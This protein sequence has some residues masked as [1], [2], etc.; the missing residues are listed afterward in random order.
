[1]V[2]YKLQNL[3]FTVHNLPFTILVSLSPL[4][5]AI[6]GSLFSDQS[7][8]EIFSD[9][10]FVRL[11]VRVEVSLAK[12]QARLGVIPTEAGMAIATACRDFEPDVEMLADS[13]AKASVPIIELVRQLR[14]RIGFEHAPYLHWGATTQDIMDTALVLQI[15]EALNYLEGLLHQLIDKLATIADDHRSTLMPGRTHSQQA[16]P[17][18]FGLKVA[19]WL[20]PLLRH[21][22]RLHELRPRV[23]NVQFSGAAGTLASFGD[24]GL[25]I[26][27]ALAEELGLAPPLIGWHTGRDALVETAGW[28]SLVTGSLAKIGQDIILMAQSEIGEIYESA[29]VSR[30]GSSTMPQKRN[31]VISELLVAIH[32]QN[33]QLLAGMHQAMVQEHERATHGWQLEWL[34]LP[35][36]FGM[37]AASLSKALFLANNLIVRT[38]R[39]AAN[40]AASNG[41]M[42]GEAVN[43]ALADFMDRSE[44]KVLVKD[45]V[46]RVYWEDRHL[47]DIVREMVDFPIDWGK[48]QNEANYLGATDQ[49]ID[50]VLARI[51]NKE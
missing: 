21:Q 28:L 48:L 20:A 27:K 8:R 50:K 39:M 51:K 17:I 10:E 38:D 32:R 24:E 3:P 43:F 11:L 19:Y 30:G 34:N 7:L 18:T 1:M 46:Q 37:T 31:P 33:S 23:L 40:V 49:M 2:K 29:D 13:T 47:V 26:Q 14:N 45:A 41:L 22:Q 36:I 5:S 35:Q 16:L 42:L 44:A 6:F 12:A 15:R 9:Q 4:D 25:L